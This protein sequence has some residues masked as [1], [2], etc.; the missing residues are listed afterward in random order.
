MPGKASLVEI[1]KQNISYEREGENMATEVA[2]LN[3]RLWLGTS[4]TLC[5]LVSS[6]P[7]AVMYSQIWSHTFTT[8][9]LEL[10]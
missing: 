3:F 7:P 9:H 8:V 2:S 5:T 1:H 10:R 6:H 4:E